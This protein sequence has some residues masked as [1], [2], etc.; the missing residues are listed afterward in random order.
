MFAFSYVTSR[1]PMQLDRQA[2]EGKDACV[3]GA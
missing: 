1:L 3:E 2:V